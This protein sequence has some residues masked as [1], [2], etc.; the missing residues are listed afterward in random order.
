LEFAFR[1]NVDGYVFV[2]DASGALSPRAREVVPRVYHVFDVA[3]TAG[4]TLVASTGA[5][6]PGDVA[7]L[8]R[9]APAA[10]FADDG[11]GRPFRRVLEYYPER[12][13]DDV[14]RFT[15]LLAL[16]DGAVL[17][18][19]QT[20]LQSAPAAVRLE[21]LPNRPRVL[22]MYGL[23]GDALRWVAHGGRVY[24]VASLGAAP[25]VSVSTDGG[26]TFRGVNGVT[27]QSL[28]S[29]GGALFA[30]GEEGDLWASEDGES[31]ERI[32]PP[33][34]ALRYVPS[35]LVSAPLV[36]HEGSL[37]AGSVTTGELFQAVVD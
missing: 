28:A 22:P 11:P 20:F 34:D 4:G 30:L 33:V 12:G 21:G 31:F 13:V 7:Y 27:A 6:V 8:S 29:A 15:Y 35:P 16:P 17:A 2:S 26:R 10:I 19:M 25:R 32:A 3:R 23:R 37:W 1:W 9:R 18:G 24:H 36:V 5:Y 14:V